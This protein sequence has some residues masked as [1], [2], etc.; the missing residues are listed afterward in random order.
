M[1]NEKMIKR[2]FAAV[3]LSGLLTPCLL[4]IGLPCAA[5]GASLI[6][7]DGR[8]YAEIVISGGPTR[9]T[10]LAAAAQAAAGDGVYG[11]RV[12]RVVEYVEPL[13]RL[14]AQLTNPREG[15][16]LARALVRSRKGLKIDGKLDE[17]LWGTVRTYRLGEL[18]TG[19]R[20]FCATS[21]HMAWVGDALCLGIT[22][23]D[24]DMEN[25]SIATTR[26]DDPKI[27]FGDVVEVLIETQ[28]DA[29]YQ[30]AISPSGAVTDLDREN[31]LDARWDS[32]AEVATHRSPDEWTVEVRLPAA[33]ES[34]KDLNAL[35][36]IAGRR[37]SETY[38]W[39]VNICRQRERDN[40]TELSAWSPTGTSRFNVPRKF[41]KVYAR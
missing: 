21:V 28:S 31:R 2:H 27:W 8:P 10:K 13:K 6:V 29:Y 5:F 15:V 18:Q 4:S 35:H 19:R 37:P 7:K 17:E 14:R 32:G 33:G 26:K 12:A 25:L 34:A 23:R 20:P 9:M 40:G 30:I 1:E 3:A 11:K 24:S 39:Y 22:C 38:P 41:G 16:P 36:G